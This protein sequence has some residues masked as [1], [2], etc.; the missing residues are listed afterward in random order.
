[1]AQTAEAQRSDETVIAAIAAFLAVGA[2]PE[3]TGKQLA[4]SSIFVGIPAGVVL[5]VVALAL[6]RPVHVTGTISPPKGDPGFPAVGA[7]DSK[8]DF[9]RAAYIRSATLRVYE[10]TRKGK[11]LEEA[12]E[13]EK[14][15]FRLH[16]VAQQ[17]RM[18]AAKLVDLAAQ[19]HGP[20]LGW[21]AKM[22]ARTSA[23]CRAA[24]GKNFDPLVPPAIGYPGSVH[25]DCRCKPGRPF[26][27]KPSISVLR[28]AA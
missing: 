7:I 21:Y 3:A 19:K 13:T 28:K 2:G 8:A 6:S 12:T 24:N 1:M 22:D 20:L 14:R 15:F 27:G 10:D 5:S 18:D 26:K 23:E 17:N 9:Y 16:V 4:A 11:T 25:P